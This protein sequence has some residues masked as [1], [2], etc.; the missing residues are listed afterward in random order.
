MESEEILTLAGKKLLIK[1]LCE[2]REVQALIDTGATKTLINVKNFERMAKKFKSRGTVKFKTAD[3]NYLDTSKIEGV[4]ITIGGQEIVW[5]IHVGNISQDMIIG[6]DLL[7][8]LSSIIDFRNKS[9]TIGKQKVDWEDKVDVIIEKAEDAQEEKN[10]KK[11]PVYN[12]SNIKIPGESEIVIPINGKF[13]V[14]SEN[15]YFEPN[16]E[17]NLSVVMS[18]SIFKKDQD[19]LINMINVNR[20]TIRIKKGTLLGYVLPCEEVLIVEEKNCEMVG[21]DIVQEKVNTILKG[22]DNLNSENEEE[23]R[24]ILI[25]YESVFADNETDLGHFTS[26]KHKIDTGNVEP[27]K[28]PMRRVALNK[29][30]EIDNQVDK[31]LAAGV[32]RPSLSSWAAVPHLVE[33]ADGSLR[34]VIDYRQLNRVT[35]KDVYPLPNMGDCVDALA[36]NKYFS[37]ID[38]ISAYWQIPMCDE[39]AEKT[40]FRTRKGLFEFIRLPFGL[41][42]SPGTYMRAMNLV[43]GELNWRVA[44]AFLDD[45]CILGKSVED[46]MKNI[47]LVLSRFKEYGFKL[48]PKKCSFFKK[49][50]EFLGREIGKQGITLTD[51]SIEVIQN[52]R[53]PR[54]VKEVQA[55]VGLLNF[56]R[57]FIKNFSYLIKP[58]Q[59]IV[60]SKNYKWEKEQQEVF[61]L[62]KKKLLSPEILSIPN[63][64]GEFRLDCDAS[65]DCIGA[66]LLQRQKGR[67]RVISYGS[68]ALTP[69]QRKYCTTR[70]ELLAIVRFVEQYRHYLLGKHFFIRTDHSSL[71]WLKNFKHIEG[72]M[73]RWIERLEMF[74]FT[75]IHRKG[76]LHANADALSRRPEENECVN[77][78]AHVDLDKLPCGGCRYCTRFYDKWRSF[79]LNIDNVING[80]EQVN[81]IN[82]SGIC[83]LEREEIQEEQGK[84]D[85]LKLLRDYLKK[86]EVPANQTYMLGGKEQKRYWVEKDL[87][88]IVEGIIFKKEDEIH[89][90]RVVIPESLKMKVLDICHDKPSSAHQALKRTKHRIKNSYYWIKMSKDIKNYV[91]GCGI[92]NKNKTGDRKNRHKLTR[93]ISSRRQQKPNLA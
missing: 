85:D 29:Q 68:Y 76:K 56:H 48:K 17:S 35:K 53:T 83:G 55:F 9:I 63:S 31:M 46:H 28:I 87:F 24:R 42:N 57:S 8:H 34:F 38:C 47:E 22:C 73:A 37:K 13:D 61:E 60:K 62:M 75:I 54:N 20:G 1:C 3:G 71:Q 66:E 6:L 5:G 7:E 33:K 18:R 65:N 30:K 69:E 92:C 88:E 26:I 16:K 52:W 36:G 43:L 81:M 10:Y 74:N 91:E 45:I 49:K 90:R 41:T 4:K 64:E 14:G 77:Y 78:K 12:K 86:G 70:K 93:N 39:D 15:I 40:A 11:I 32:I 72:Q 89:K 21:I 51:E 50:I 25:R 80:L 67:W 2:G 44:L 84:D 23:L 58:L 27:I 79:E 19:P 59:E 82:I